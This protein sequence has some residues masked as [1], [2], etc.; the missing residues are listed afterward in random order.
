MRLPWA[1]LAACPND[2]AGLLTAAALPVPQAEAARRLLI[3]WHPGMIV[4]QVCCG[5][6][7]WGVIEQNYC[8]RNLLAQPA[9]FHCDFLCAYQ[10]GMEQQVDHPFVL[11]TQPPS[12]AGCYRC[13]WLT[14]KSL[15]LM[16]NG[17]WTNTPFLQ[18]KQPDSSVFQMFH[19][20]TWAHSSS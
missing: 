11:V 9:L 20:Q 12:A 8:N 17:W 7:V 10:V 18:P 16:L 15:L 1:R 5:S 19:Q 13:W 14:A 2:P 6:W 3:V 4:V